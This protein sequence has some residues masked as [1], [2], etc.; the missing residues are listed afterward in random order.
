MDK[1]EMMDSWFAIKREMSVWS[2]RLPKIVASYNKYASD[3][4]K[5][6]YTAD[7]DGDYETATFDELM[8]FTTQSNIHGFRH[9]VLD[10]EV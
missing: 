10:A 9:L 2:S 4:Q 5:M 1:S 7:K 8:E 6:W 3:Y